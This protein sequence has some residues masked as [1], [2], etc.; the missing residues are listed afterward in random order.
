MPRGFLWLLATAALAQQYPDGVGRAE[1]ER[2]CKGCHEVARSVSKR[3]DRD[4]WGSTMAKMQALGMKGSD[5]DFSLILDYLAANFPA[6]ESPRVN[7][8]KASAIE[9][10]SG[11]GLRRS[12]AASVI[13][14]RAKNGDFK[15]LDDL[16]KVPLIDAARIGEKKDRIEF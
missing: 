9:L 14:Y 15:S 10:E 4:G 2:V 11:L 7:V 8:N 12:Q 1:M 16:K 6:E 5:R 3:Q 13:A